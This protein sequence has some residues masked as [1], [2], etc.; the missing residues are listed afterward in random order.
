MMVITGCYNKLVIYTGCENK[1]ISIN[2]SCD[3]P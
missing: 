1:H 2:V 3:K